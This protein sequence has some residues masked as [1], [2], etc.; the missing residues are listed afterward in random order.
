[1]AVVTQSEFTKEHGILGYLHYLVFPLDLLFSGDEVFEAGREQ[2]VCELTPILCWLMPLL[3]LLSSFTYLSGVGLALFFLLEV[4]ILVF[5]SIIYCW[6]LSIGFLF[7]LFFN[8]LLSFI[9]MGVLFY[10]AMFLWASCG[11]ILIVIA[12]IAVIAFF[13]RGNNDYYNDRDDW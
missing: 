12:V 7:E 9:I 6:R 3:L 13:S 8:Y 11:M 10:A 5:I 1:M 4:F 2:R